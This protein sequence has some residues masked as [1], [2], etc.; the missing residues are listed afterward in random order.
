MKKMFFPF[1]LIGFLIFMLPNNLYGQEA[2]KPVLKEGNWWRVKT[3]VKR[4]GDTGACHFDYSKYIVKIE[5]GKPQVYGLSGD[6]VEKKEKIDCQRVIGILLD[7]GTERRG[8]LK[9]PFAV[10]STWDERYLSSSSGRWRYPNSKVLAWEKVRTPKG[11]LDTF[12]IEQW[13]GDQ[14]TPRAIYYYSPLAKAIILLKFSS[15]RTDVTY[16][17]VDFNV[18]N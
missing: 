10:K 17:V 16:T 18:S 3:E 1:A 4:V 9:F 15:R 2:K 5:Q 12:K 7:L 8:Y 11:E 13:V 6:S 14:D